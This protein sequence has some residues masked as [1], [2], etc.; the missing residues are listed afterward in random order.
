MGSNHFA[1]FE[2]TCQVYNLR[3][4]GRLKI[5]PDCQVWNT[6]PGCQYGIKSGSDNKKNKDNMPQCITAVVWPCRPI[7]RINRWL[8]SS[9]ESC[10]H[11]N[12][13]WRIGTLV[14]IIPC[15]MLFPTT[16]RSFFLVAHVPE[17]DVVWICLNGSFLAKTRRTEMMSF[18]HKKI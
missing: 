15:M 13:S 2:R 17:V 5:H 9:L 10:G 12:I 11:K 14:A 3:S 18:L 8:R 16:T 1:I 7:G 4:W 6:L